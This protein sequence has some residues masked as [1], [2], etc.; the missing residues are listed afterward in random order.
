MS[1]LAE[2]PIEVFTPG[3]WGETSFLPAWQG[4]KGALYED[5]AYGLLLQD[6]ARVAVYGRQTEP[7]EEGVVLAADGESELIR[8][9]NVLLV[10]LEVLTPARSREEWGK[11]FAKRD[12]FSTV[13]L[14]KKEVGLPAQKLFSRSTVTGPRPLAHAH[15]VEVLPYRRFLRDEETQQEYGRFVG[16]MIFGKARNGRPANK[17]VTNFGN[18]VNEGSIGGNN[19]R[20][21]LKHA[22]IH[23]L[24]PMV[25]G[26]AYDLEPTAMNAKR[27]DSIPQEGIVRVRGAE[28]CATGTV[29]TSPPR[30]NLSSL[31]SGLTRAVSLTDSLAIAGRIPRV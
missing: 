3:Y 2:Q 10:D 16:L 26:A 9:G 28:V 14:D 22:A 29:E 12:G 31:R 18:L 27:W 15:S 11:E 30:G 8:P 21:P 24:N 1:D 6:A 19:S 7:L 17:I 20:N 5:P 13:L 25:I 4:S 23:N